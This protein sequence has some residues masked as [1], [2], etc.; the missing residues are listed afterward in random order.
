MLNQEFKKATC[1]N[2]S[3]LATKTII[4]KRNAIAIKELFVIINFRKF[5]N[6]E[7]NGFDNNL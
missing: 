1:F 6:E 5:L 4:A 7:Y 2:K 3:K